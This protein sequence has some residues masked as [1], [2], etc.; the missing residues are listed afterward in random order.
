M[1]DSMHWYVFPSQFSM[2]VIFLFPI[3]VAVGV[4]VAAV[5]QAMVL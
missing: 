2:M 1:I 3:A 4:G 5:T